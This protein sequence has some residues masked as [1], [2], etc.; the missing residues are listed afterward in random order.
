MKRILFVSDIDGTLVENGILS[1]RVAAA[2]DAFAAG[3]NLFALATGRGRDSV[4]G[5]ARKLSV[6]TPCIILS[7]AA[8]YEPETETV[9]RLLPLRGGVLR[10]L[11]N[12]LEHHPSTAI[13]VF[14]ASGLS[15][16]RLNSFLRVNGIREEISRPLCGLSSLEGKD[17]LKL[18]FCC[19]DVEEMRLMLDEEFSD[20][21]LYRWHFSHSICTEVVSP[22]VSKGN[23]LR[24]LIEELPQK[25][26]LV[27]AAGDSPNDLSLFE[28][29]DLCFAP[30]TAFR[31]VLD[32]ADYVI[33]PAESG[34]VADALAILM[35]KQ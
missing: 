8:L 16:L 21:T 25:P 35:K 28:C 11:K 17:I 4:M 10:H 2:V 29:A 6:I 1:D 32:R 34:G 26:E 22:S 33:S 19:E 23:A 9:S 27:A 31:S 30:E 13:Q 5:I 18:G 15:N 7:G 14:T 12:V 3:G 20:E 24:A